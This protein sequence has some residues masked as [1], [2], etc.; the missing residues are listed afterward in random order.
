MGDVNV[1]NPECCRRSFGDSL[2]DT[3]KRLLENPKL[4]PRKVTADR[5]E[6]CRACDHFDALTT[7]CSQCL[8]IMY[9]KTTFA[10]VR[11]PIDKWEEYDE[12]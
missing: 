8:C 1:E 12:N 4:A 6:I 11:C 5:M 2:R 9:L 3:A 7:Q 10:N